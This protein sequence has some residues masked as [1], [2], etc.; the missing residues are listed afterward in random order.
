[1][2]DVFAVPALPADFEVTEAL[3]QREQLPVD[4][5]REPSAMSL[6][7]FVTSAT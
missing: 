6:R 1:M 3:L 5:L 2:T 7:A 4:A